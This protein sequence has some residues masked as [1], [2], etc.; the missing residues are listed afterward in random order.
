MSDSAGK[1]VWPLDHYAIEGVRITDWLAPGVVKYHRRLATTLTLLLAAGFTI[2]HVEEFRPSS[3]QVE[4]DPT[5]AEELDRPMFL[6]VQA[7]KSSMD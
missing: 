7:A 1:R 3:E 4:K 6:M 2:G 5:L